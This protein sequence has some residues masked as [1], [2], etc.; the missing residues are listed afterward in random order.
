MLPMPKRRY[1]PRTMSKSRSVLG[2]APIMADAESAMVRVRGPAMRFFRTSIS[3]QKGNANH[4]RTRLQALL[5][6]LIYGSSSSSPSPWLT[7]CPGA[8]D[9]GSPG[10]PVVASCIV[11]A[12]AELQELPVCDGNLTRRVSR[13]RDS[14]PCIGP[15]GSSGWGSSPAE[16]PAGDLGRES[17]DRALFPRLF[18]I[19][20][21]AGLAA[22]AH[23]RRLRWRG[24]EKHQME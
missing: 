7:C 19:S 3:D 15:P 11:H 21:W 22:L 4:R 18:F 5:P 17:A 16:S 24:W 2:G 1:H 9:S 8:T 12:D 14:P 23:I 6:L 10:Y 20:V 13:G